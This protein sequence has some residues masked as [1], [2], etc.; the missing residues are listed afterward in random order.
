MIL[1]SFSTSILRFFHLSIWKTSFILVQLAM[2]FYRNPGFFQICN[3]SLGQERRFKRMSSQWSQFLHNHG[4]PVRTM[5]HF[6]DLR[7]PG[8]SAFH[9]IVCSE[10]MGI[11]YPSPLSSV[12]FVS[13]PHFL[14]SHF[15]RKFRKECKNLCSHISFCS[16]IFDTEKITP[17]FCVCVFKHRWIISI[18]LNREKFYCQLRVSA[19]I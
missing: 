7:S 18:W 6:Q 3:T 17:Q 9:S 10:S 2:L 13:S 11:S 19:A 15:P 1:R 12:V 8:N 16:W 5:A 4:N 14:R